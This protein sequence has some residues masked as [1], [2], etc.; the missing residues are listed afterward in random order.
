MTND[1]FTKEDIVC[2]LKQAAN[3][4]TDDCAYGGV[5]TAGAIILGVSEDTINELIS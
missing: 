2:A 4:V 5:R 1:Y 3:E